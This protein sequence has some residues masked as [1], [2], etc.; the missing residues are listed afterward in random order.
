M[1][2][3]TAMLLEERK[4]KNSVVSAGR[5]PLNTALWL[6]SDWPADY[7]PMFSQEHGKIILYWK[8]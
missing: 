1:L 8:S 4:R 3:V 6:S 7:K 2:E 5:L